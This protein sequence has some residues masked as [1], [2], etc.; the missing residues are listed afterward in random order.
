MKVIRS[1]NDKEFEMKKFYAEKWVLHQTFCVETPQQN[2][3]IK[4]KHQHIINIVRVLKLQNGLHTRYWS[5]ISLK[6]FSHQL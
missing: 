1:D 3:R 5:I 6:E 2:G 4:R